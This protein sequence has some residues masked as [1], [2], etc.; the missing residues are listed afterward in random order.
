MESIGT[1]LRSIR[2]DPVYIIG[3]ILAVGLLVFSIYIAGPWYPADPTSLVAAAFETPLARLVLG[4]VY[5]IPSIVVIG[6]IWKGNGWKRAGTFSMAA[7]YTFIA[8]LRVISFGLEPIIWL[9]VL[10]C[11]LVSGMVYL[12]VS[13]NGED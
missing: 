12:H 3:V 9:F 7:C 13:L 6:G 4:I 8:L 5:A 2:K 10:V 1:T 11:G